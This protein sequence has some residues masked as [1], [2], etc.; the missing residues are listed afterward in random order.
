ME[1]N[2]LVTIFFLAYNYEKLLEKAIQPLL[3]QTYPNIELIISNNQSTDKT[4]EVI[5]KIQTRN[6]KII[7]RKN[8]PN[9][10]T[11]EFCDVCA[12]NIPTAKKGKLY[13]IC[14][15]HCNSCL[16]SGL[17]KGEYI[18]FC[19][20]DDIYEKDI[21]KKEAEFLTQN[22]EVAAVFTLGNIINE[23]DKIVGQSK[24]PKEL[25]G[26]NI[27]NFME[28]FEAILKHGNTFLITPTFMVRKE[29]FDKVGLFDDQGPFGG[30]DDL[31]MWLRIL[32]KYPIGIIQENLINWRTVGSRGKKYN[33]LRTEKADF[34]K[35]MD[36]YL[37][38]KF[39]INKINKKSLR[40]YRYQEDFDDTFKAMHFLIKNQPEEA[41][42][43]INKPFSFD[44][45]LAF[46]ENISVRRAEVLAIKIL[47]LVGVNVG[48]G[49]H[50]GKLLNKIIYKAF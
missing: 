34:F 10:K 41:K 49:K 39:Y 48:L 4:E 23:N 24:F 15:N 27:F 43:L 19:H 46:F 35:V 45:L 18:I 32:E 21:I 40:Q 38:D 7:Y 14:F 29:I 20:Q 42:K 16:N 30:S 11:D 8:I 1:N 36:Y 33:Q 25:K 12:E 3:E 44:L 17:A 31:E 6:P 47:M 22:P 28:I 50:L 9:I 5:K 37:T 2:P 13:D 26:K